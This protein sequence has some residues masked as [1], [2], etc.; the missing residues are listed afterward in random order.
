MRSN[1]CS[2]DSASYQAAGVQSDF[3]Q[4]CALDPV[5]CNDAWQL[6]TASGTSAAPFGP[7]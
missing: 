3:T 7:R 2:D 6:L 1:V 5:D 4:L